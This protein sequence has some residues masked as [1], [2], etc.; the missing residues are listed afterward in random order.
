MKPI[1]FFGSARLLTLALSATLLALL[2]RV[3]APASP[4]V[5]AAAPKRIV[6]I[7]IDTWRADALG[8]SGSGKVATPELDRL[9]REGLWC[10]KAWAPSVL[11]APSHASIL[12]GRFADRHGIRDNG[13]GKLAGTLPSLAPILRKAGWATAGFVSGFPLIGAFGF[14]RG[15][16]HWDDRVLSAGPTAM[17]PRE[18]TGNRTLAEAT[19]WLA[20]GPDRYFLWIH[21]YDPHIPYLPPEPFRSKTP[22]GPYY[23]EV[24]FVDSLVGELRR[25]ID[26]RGD[27]ETLWVVTGD[28]G[29]ALGEHG[30]ATH[31]L[32]V[33][34]STARVP[35]IVSRPGVL[36]P[37]ELE[38]ARL[39]DL[40]PTILELAGIAIPP[41]MEGRS[42][43]RPSTEPFSTWVESLYPFLEFGAAPVRALSDGRYKVLQLPKPE[44]YDLAAD[45]EETK[46]LVA[47]DRP[48]IRFLFGRLRQR[49]KGDSAKSGAPASP[50]DP[51]KKALRSLGYLGAGGGMKLGKE[52]LD[53]K[54][55]LPHLRQLEEARERVRV[56]R[57]DEAAPAYRALLGIF[58]RSPI[59]LREL[60][61]LQAMTGRLPE[62]EGSLVRSL[63]LDP[64]SS[65]TLLA[66]GNVAAG[67][68]DPAAAERHFSA[69]LEL[70]GNDA[71]GN[72]NLGILLARK[73]GRESEAIR[74]L[75]RF[76]EL[77]P[78]DPEAPKIREMIGKLQRGRK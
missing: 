49:T 50:S 72:L 25:K 38:R 28:H 76:L 69:A 63:A 20:K 3:A 4:S 12:T 24:A 45:P 74:R 65:E 13:D 26:P 77:S 53:P 54:E 2:P 17:S 42:L 31:G 70:D 44:A 51:G 66:L 7:T 5:P 21:F 78:T 59:L 64:A 23:G 71:E 19:G 18:R 62:A 56:R 14:S 58:P 8:L 35:L 60:G 15:F 48:E 55:L 67:R 61:I 75:E 16:D 46:N 39:V 73:P 52:G 34:D 33:Y 41:G 22:A 57:F 9:A 27:G 11:T 40:A 68:G 36:P 32:F 47:A 37:R 1:P 6:L 29:E 10:R 30:E 43:L